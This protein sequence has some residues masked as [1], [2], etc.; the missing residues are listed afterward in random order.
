MMILLLERA[1]AVEFLLNV[2]D[3]WHFRSNS[4]GKLL[5]ATVCASGANAAAV[6]I[7]ISCAIKYLLF[8]WKY[9]KSFKYSGEQMNK[10]DDDV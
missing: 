1:F 10:D 6:V 3:L 9:S 8:L 7:S 5:S 4:V 2:T